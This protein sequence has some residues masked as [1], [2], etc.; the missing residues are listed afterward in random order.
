MTTSSR[1]EPAA[2]DLVLDR[3][4]SSYPDAPIAAVNQTGFFVPMPTS[5]PLAQHQVIQNHATAL[6]L[7]VPEDMS[8]VIDT[9]TL[10]RDT[11]S[12]KGAVRLN[13]Q[14]DREI[15]LHYID[16]THRHGVYIGLLEIASSEDLMA[17]FEAATPLRPKVAMVRK[18]EMAFILAVD[19]A[20]TQILGWT[21]DEMVGQR[22]LQFIDPEDHPR[23][24]SNWM[25]M[26]RVPKSRRRV[27][28]R[29]RHQDGSW[30]WFEITNRNLLNDPEHNCVVTE[31]VDITDEM[32]A[33]E[34]LRSREHLLRRLTDTLPVGICQVDAARRI[35]YSN[36]RLGA[37]V[38]RPR[39]MTIDELFARL[40][41][42]YRQPLE[43]ALDAVLHAGTDQDLEVALRRR[44]RDVRR[45][46]VSL[47][48]LTGD[49][50][51]ITGAI[52]CVTDMTE[53]FRMRAELE[54][55]A[56]FDVLTRC[57]NRA[58]ILRLLENALATPHAGCGTAVIF[59]D[60]DR[61]KDLNDRLGHAAG[62]AL[63]VEVAARL[64]RAVRGADVVGRLGG[65][66]F[67]I[68]LPSVKSA[69][70]ARRIAERVAT[71]LGAVPIRLV[72]E[73]VTP[74]ASIG[75]A[76]SADPNVNG[77]ALVARADEAMYA[78]KRR[79]GSHPTITEAA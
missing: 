54:H 55:R 48:A 45:C 33:Q 52:V 70:R 20:T 65:D 64:Q 24:I 66:E 9:W 22:T 7:V 17:A 59:L 6:E 72:G 14:P 5:V 42:E 26:L 19:E 12:A 21:A 3:L 75:V 63:L 8:I 47:R 32:A 78:S 1:L 62:D 68:I 71:T 31:M 41:P 53:S 61:F 11:G 51:T 69:A 43:S 50:G 25:D 29:H 16:A 67:L 34:T 60:L 74:C 57:Y 46:T 35:V 36:T 77:D 44:Q 23:A 18:N 15:N 79:R 30:R 73:Q 56:T 38:G 28:L 39:A 58:S 76:W 2:L 37:I 4:L 10:A 27:R 49:A 40:Q 13:S